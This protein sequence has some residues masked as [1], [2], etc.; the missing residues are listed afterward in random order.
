VF[1][2]T[3]LLHCGTCGASITAEEKINRH[4]SHYVY[5][6]CTHKKREIVCREKC[7]E[8]GQLQDQILEF[9]RTVCLDPEEVEKSLDT[10]ALERSEQRQTESGVRQSLERALQS[11]RRNLDNLT[12]LRY[13][14][15]IRDEEFLRQ[16]EELNR[17]EIQL[18]QRLK[19]LETEQ[20]IEPS[21][22]LFLFSNRAVFWLT[23]GS[24]ED[25]RLIL[26]TVGSNPTLKA[27]KLSIGAAKPFQILQK[28]RSTRAWSAI[29][30]DVRTFFREN[31]EFE[32][33]LLPE[34]SLGQ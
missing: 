14:E 12:K 7:L 28:E 4:G 31:P 22:R 16:R 26:S 34:P 11:C 33:P 20:W 10:I 6:H 18:T 19:D 3:G 27:K 17:E 25:K 9:L 23:H 2:Y 29:V 21:R 32:I 8:E 24:P 5:Y 15:L 30:N 13:R 1:A